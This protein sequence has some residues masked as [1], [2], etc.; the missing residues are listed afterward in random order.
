MIE[1]DPEPEVPVR[2]KPLADVVRGVL[3]NVIGVPAHGWL[4]G[5]R[6]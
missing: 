2:S 6:A 3:K 1:E 4:I 5:H